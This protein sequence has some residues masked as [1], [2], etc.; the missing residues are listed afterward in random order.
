MVQYEAVQE[1]LQSLTADGA[2][3]SVFLKG[4][5]GRE[6]EDEYSD[7]DLYCLVEEEEVDAFKERRIQHLEAYRP[8][9]FW[10]DLF[11][12]A[13][14]IIAIYENWLHID[15]FVVTHAT[16]EPKD[17]IKVLYDPE[18]QMKR[19]EDKQSL[20][21]S[22]EKRSDHAL[23]LSWFLF[24]YKKASERGNDIW[25]VEMLRHVCRDLSSL[26]L[27]KYAPHRAELGLKNIP[28]DLSE[29]HVQAMTSI[30]ETLTPSR[31]QEAVQQLLSIIL[32]EKEWIEDCIT[33]NEKGRAL[34]HSV[35]KL[36]KV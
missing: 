10:E 13:P 27:A 26:L 22:E 36:Y 31:H 19:Y 34:F 21:L 7:I 29:Q 3:Q 28:Y 23:D 5:M 32:E 35:L 30:Y 18:C 33:T 6:E 11:I 24:R 14:Q 1:I 12:I 2:V 8:L 17:N 4:S 20:V 15:L 16:Y 9:L 25:A